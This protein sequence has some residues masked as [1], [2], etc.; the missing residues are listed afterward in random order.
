[1]LPSILFALSFLLPFSF[2]LVAPRRDPLHLPVTRHHRH[3][4]RN[5]EAD[6]AH[7]AA[8]SAG[9]IHKYGYDSPAGV[10]R[11]AQTTDIGITN[12]VRHACRPRI[13]PDHV[14]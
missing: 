8:L 7:Y 9:L 1:M 13:R 10:S 4:R 5:G 6:V 14:M 3:T 11:R 12:Q 2:A